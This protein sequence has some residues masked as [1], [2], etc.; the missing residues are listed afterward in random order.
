M[1]VAPDF[2][3]F[4]HGQAR[5]LLPAAHLSSLV[6]NCAQFLDFAQIARLGVGSLLGFGVIYVQ[7]VLFQSGFCDFKDGFFVVTVLW[8]EINIVSVFNVK[9]GFKVEVL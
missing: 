7:I 4:G 9:R 8:E 1:T 6:K 3:V 2:R 5:K